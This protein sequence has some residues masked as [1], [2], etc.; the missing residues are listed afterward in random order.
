MDRFERLRLVEAVLFAASKPLGESDL[1]PYL[2][3]GADVRSLVAELAG[4][5]GN[6]GVNVVEIDGKWAF[7]TAPD[8][9]DRLRLE[10]AV[11]RKLS[12]AALE[13]LAIV[14]YHQPVTRAEI[15][16]IRGVALSRGTLDTL[17]EAG[18]V[19]PRGRRRT[20]GRPVTWCTTD[21]FLDHFGLGSLDDLP[22]VRELQASGLLDARPAISAFAGPVAEQDVGPAHPG[23]EEDAEPL[24]PA[25]FDESTVAED[26]D[27]DDSD[28][29]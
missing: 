20:P 11:Q 12:R 26:G 23:D 10:A 1:A 16:E 19:R 5:Y 7:R 4:L 29:R 6:R 13:T 22:G 28:R 2:P 8:L 3:E 15:E 25:D 17:L 27:A 21:G 18:W 14:A 24:L 9:G